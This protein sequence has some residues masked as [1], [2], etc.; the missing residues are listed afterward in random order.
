VVG[1]ASS[2]A[3]VVA[4]GLVAPVVLTLAL[5]LAHG[6]PATAEMFRFWLGEV[7]AKAGG[8]PLLNQSLRAQ[9]WRWCGEP[10]LGAGL[11][12]GLWAM[13]TVNVLWR[14]S[15]DLPGALVDAAVAV[16][17]GQLMLPFAWFHYFLVLFPVVCAV[18]F[19][20]H[21]LRLGL[22]GAGFVLLGL[23]DRDLVGLRLWAMAA[24]QGASLWGAL[25]WTLAGI[26][27]REARRGAPSALVPRA[28]YPVNS[29]GVIGPP[30]RPAA[31]PITPKEFTGG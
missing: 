25:L 22:L 6:G 15:R 1:R 8:D 7:V 29:F 27:W 4:A 13:W 5:V 30:P 10:V 12:L 19:E 11:G 24:A 21:P 26:S 17:L 14:P 16:A 18:A 3:R 28:P 31:D 20:R 9:L 23:L 2:R